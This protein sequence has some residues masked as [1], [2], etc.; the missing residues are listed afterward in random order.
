MNDIGVSH[1]S[2]TCDRADSQTGW[3]DLDHYFLCCIQYGVSRRF[4]AI[5]RFLRHYF[6]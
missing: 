2:C 5:V 3:P 1:P 6:D 4:W